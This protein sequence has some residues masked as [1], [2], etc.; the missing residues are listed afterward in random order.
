MERRSRD[1]IFTINNPFDDLNVRSMNPNHWETRLFAYMCWQLEQGSTGTIHFQGYIVLNNAYSLA[2]MKRIFSTRAH[3]EIRRGT[4]DEAVMYCTKEDT[5]ME[6][7]YHKG[8]PPQQGK[9]SDL[10]E[11]KT[12]IDGGATELSIA[13]SHFASWTRYHRS[14]HRYRLIIKPPRR[15]KP[16]VI[17]RYGPTGTGK[18]YSCRFLDPL[19]TYRKPNT[20]STQWWDGYE[21]QS[22]I[23]IDEYRGWLPYDV[24]LMI[25]DE[26]PY[27][28]QIKGGFVPLTATQIIILSNLHP[29]LWYTKDPLHDYAMIERR[30]DVIEFYPE[31]YTSGPPVVVVEKA[32]LVPEEVA[33]PEIVDLTDADS[34]CEAITST[35]DSHHGSS[36]GLHSNI[37]RSELLAAVLE[38]P[39]RLV[40]S[41]T[42]RV[43]PGAPLRAYTK[44][45]RR[46]P[47]PSK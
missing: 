35:Q 19:D 44:R 32:P 9:R 38:T 34:E 30:I 45:K 8:V 14:F 33:P 17:V 31:R 36:T 42:I 20:G 41:A 24:L 13:Q 10:E 46:S 27:I 7:P 40:R 23:V 15:E 43:P 1:W 29:S 4:H 37:D 6:G 28:L 18:S 12:L 3:W 39:P 11:I 25:L 21:G 5:R 2:Q 26:S 22:I 16:H 47:S